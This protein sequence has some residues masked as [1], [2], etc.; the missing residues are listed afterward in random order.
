LAKDRK[1]REEFLKLVRKE[2]ERN[3]ELLEGLA[4]K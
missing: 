3:R 1:E 2:V 4:E